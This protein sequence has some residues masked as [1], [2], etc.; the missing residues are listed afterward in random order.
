MLARVTR[1]EPGFDGDMETACDHV[2]VQSARVCRGGGSP[3]RY[4]RAERLAASKM[5]R[6]MS[7]YRLVARAVDTGLFTFDNMLTIYPRKR[8]I[9]AHMARADR[10]GIAL[11][12]SE[13]LVA[14]LGQLRP[15]HSAGSA[16][17]S[18][19]SY[20]GEWGRQGE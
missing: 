5:P 19:P 7:S 13:P 20:R 14:Q 2:P 17:C 18:H 9:C 10:E 8:T 12:G 4:R 3:G 6:G 1:F 11:D 16:L 15:L